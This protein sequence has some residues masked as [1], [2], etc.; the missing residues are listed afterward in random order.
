MHK[1]T[2]AAHKSQT[3]ALLGAVQDFSFECPIHVFKSDDQAQ[4]K[5]RRVAGIISTDNPDRQHEVILQDGLDFADFI[6]H[7]WFNDNHSAGTTDILGYP[8]TVKSFN[9]GEALPDGSRAETNCTWVEGYLLT[10]KKAEQVW[11]LAQALQGTNRRLGY[12]VEGSIEKRSGPGDRTIAKAK[13]RNVAVTNCPVNVDSRL[14]ILARSLTA[15]SREPVNKTMSMA[16][17]G[18]VG[19][20]V[21]KPDKAYSGEGAGRALAREDLDQDTY[22]P[23]ARKRRA[24]GKTK[25]S[26]TLTYAEA[27]ELVRSLGADVTETT[28]KAVVLAADALVRAGL[29]H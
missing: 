11:E 1:L 18:T 13:I 2:D 16:V 21:A 26:Q 15:L 12:S 28:A 4:G 7:G 22:G 25:K 19:P 20:D 24:K 29:V 9:R 8:E 14:E 10:T 27:T 17:S 23:N 5:Q 3:D 6:N